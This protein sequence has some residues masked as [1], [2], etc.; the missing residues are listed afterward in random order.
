[1]DGQWPQ[2]NSDAHTDYDR[3]MGS[4]SEY[5]LMLQDLGDDFDGLLGLGGNT[6]MG[7]TGDASAAATA[8]QDN[9][10]NQRKVQWRGRRRNGERTR[11]LEAYTIYF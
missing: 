6:N 8:E 1:M 4:P 11:Q 10:G 9:N 2:E 5:N 7:N 3:A